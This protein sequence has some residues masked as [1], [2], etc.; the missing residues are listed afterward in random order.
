MSIFCGKSSIERSKFLAV[1]ADP[2]CVRHFPL[3]YCAIACG[4]LVMFSAT[5]RTW[6]GPEDNKPVAE[7]QAMDDPTLAW[8][9]QGPC[10]KAA[11]TAFVVTTDTVVKRKESLRYLAFI[12]D[13]K[14]KKDGKIAPWLYELAKHAEQ[15]AVQG[16]K[17][18]TS[19]I[20]LPPEIP[21]EG[22]GQTQ[23]ASAQTSAEKSPP[24]KEGSKSEKK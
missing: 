24:A 11:I 12:L 1:L 2:F 3:F 17:D 9:A 8:E 6:E 5:G 4:S 23:E 13:S 18:V 14:R 21:P 20:Y 22:E 16:C 15:G 10:V 19:K 7:I